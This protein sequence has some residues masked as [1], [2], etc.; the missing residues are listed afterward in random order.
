MVKRGKNFPISGV[1]TCG[2]GKLSSSAKFRENDASQIYQRSLFVKQVW[3][4]GLL[5]M[6]AYSKV[7]IQQHLKIL[8]W[9]TS[10]LFLGQVSMLK[11]EV[12][13]GGID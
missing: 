5:E 3:S 12:I 10:F 7:E 9:E 6:R 13:L 1:V 8:R 11:T 4:R 2:L